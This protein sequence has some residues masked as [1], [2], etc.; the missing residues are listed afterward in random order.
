MKNKFNSSVLHDGYIYGLD[1][2]IL[3]CVGVNT[4]VQMEGRRYGLD[5]CC[6]P[7]TT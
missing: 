5:R 7:V 1:E 6:W 3:S 2:Q 4:G